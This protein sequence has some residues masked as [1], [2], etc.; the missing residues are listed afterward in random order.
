M[1]KISLGNSRF[2]I[3]DDEDYP[4]LS[5]HIWNAV[6]TTN[7]Y[8]AEASF[9]SA[10]G[11]RITKTMHCIIMGSPTGLEVDHINGN[12]LDNRRENLRVVTRRENAQNKHRG[13][14]VI[15]DPYYK[16]PKITAGVVKS[17]RLSKD[18]I[19][20]LKALKKAKVEKN[21]SDRIRA[22]LRA[23][24]RERLETKEMKKA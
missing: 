12:G 16:R 6:E 10:N 1:K 17:W 9:R 5:E 15:G 23:L 21:V 8:Y 11:E 14:D 3:V 4:K 20:L 22:G 13:K 24:A 19:L 7:T 2:T 18:D